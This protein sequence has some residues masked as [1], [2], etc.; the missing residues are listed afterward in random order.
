MPMVL[1]QS[2]KA[3]AEKL[4]KWVCMSH[5]TSHICVH[6][7]THAHTHTHTHTHTH[8]NFL[9]VA[10]IVMNVKCTRKVLN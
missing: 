10:M 8:Y 9:E 4:S 7:D 5:A 3:E 2:R 1:L 6:I